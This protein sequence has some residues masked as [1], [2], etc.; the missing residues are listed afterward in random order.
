M[1]RPFPAKP[2]RPATKIQTILTAVVREM[3]C[4]QLVPIRFASFTKTPLN[5]VALL[6]I[7]YF[8][9]LIGLELFQDLVPGARYH[10][11][12]GFRASWLSTAQ[13]PL[14]ILLVGKQ[15][16]LA[17]FTGVSHEWCEST[18]PVRR[19]VGAAPTEVEEQA[20]RGWNRKTGGRTLG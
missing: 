7:L 8:G 11:A 20:S 5:G 16:L 9:F 2:S 17:D 3:T 15:N 12:L 19:S 6:L 13:L 18:N 14:L 10:Q 4:P 1:K